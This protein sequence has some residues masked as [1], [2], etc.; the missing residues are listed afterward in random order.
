[1]NT[2]T[3]LI[4]HGGFSVTLQLAD[5][6]RQEANDD[7]ALI[8]KVANLKQ[9]ETLVEAQRKG[10]TFLKFAEE[11]RVQAKA[12]FLEMCRRI[13]A[14]H[15]AYVSATNKEVLRVAV[16]ASDFE[17]LELAKVKAAEAARIEDL[18]EID[19]RKQ[20]EVSTA[21]S[22]EELDAIQ[23]RYSN[24]AQALALPL[25]PARVDGQRI[26]EE[27]DITVT[28]ILMLDRCHPN[29]V[30]RTPIKSEIK[31]LLNAGLTVA[32]IIAKRITKSGVRVTK[33][34]I[35]TI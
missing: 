17:A 28:D 14:A 18:A 22:H 2:N 10:V 29:C 9:L 32:G 20:V 11:Q 21:T 15:K 16:I 3:Q 30:K 13:D 24:E 31:Y 27:W 12:P 23:E 4:E 8:G 1:M 7:L 33:D 25:Q 6:M 19:R 5:E 35:L 26:T 34:A